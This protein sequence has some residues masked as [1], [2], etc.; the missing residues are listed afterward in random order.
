MRL[1]PPAKQLANGVMQLPELTV[2]TQISHS[3]SQITFPALRRVAGKIPV[4][5]ADIFFHAGKTGGWNNVTNPL[6]NSK[7]LSRYNGQRQE[8]L[9]KLGCYMVSTFGK[10]EWRHNGAGE[11]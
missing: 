11:V 2:K 6:I 9:L 8:R 4:L 3:H 5:K 1:Q 7:Q 10:R